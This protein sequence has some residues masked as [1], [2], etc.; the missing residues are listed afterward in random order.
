L[1]D[2][3][4][5]ERLALSDRVNGSRPPL[6]ACL[7]AA[8]VG[9]AAGEPS[10]MQSGSGGMGGSPAG[11]GGLGGSDAAAGRA[12]AGAEIPASSNATDGGSDALAPL[13]T[14]TCTVPAT[15]TPAAMLSK[16]GCVDPHDATK[17]TASLVAYDVNSPLWSDGAEKERFIAIPDGGKIHLKDCG[18][19]PSACD[20]ANGGT[21]D[22]DGHLDVP[23]GSV[24][25]KNFLVAGKRVETRLLMYVDKDFWKG[26]S[27]EWNDAQTDATLLPNQ[28]AKPVGG[29]TWYYPAREE[30]LDVPH[31]G[32]GRGSWDRGDI[33]RGRRDGHG[34]DAG[35]RRLAG[36]TVGSS[37]QRR[38]GRGDGAG[39][40]EWRWL[41][42]Q[43]GGLAIA[44]RAVTRLDL[45]RG[46]AA[47]PAPELRWPV[48]R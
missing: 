12:D 38:G 30:C 7:A 8:L 45:A 29:Q 15:G 46:M 4:G 5:P 18:K 25:V 39:G 40:H 22:D 14:Q 32:G 10:P 41:R 24:F 37:G 28:L 2:I 35:R 23:I 36:R 11:Q 48:S 47:S 26:F 9:C 19:T 31:G 33:R 43:R 17:P 44:G 16:T 3:D 1:I 13:P 21:Y 42:L 34:R 20:V 27:Y 6:F